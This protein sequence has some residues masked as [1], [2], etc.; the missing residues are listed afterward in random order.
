MIK[1]AAMVRWLRW[2]TCSQQTWLQLLLVPV[3]GRVARTLS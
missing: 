1:G 2:R 3:W